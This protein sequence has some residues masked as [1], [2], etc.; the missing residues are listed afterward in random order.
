MFTIGEK[1]V[2]DVIG[3]DESIVKDTLRETAEGLPFGPG[4]WQ[5]ERADNADG[6]NGDKGTAD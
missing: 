3:I 6:V 2:S 5:N 1:R 4:H